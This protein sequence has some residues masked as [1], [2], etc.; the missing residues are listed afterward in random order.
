VR[1][2]MLSML[3]CHFDHSSGLV[4]FE[5]LVPVAQLVRVDVV[6]NRLPA[7][8]DFCDPSELLKG[9][10]RDV[11]CNQHRLASPIQP[12]PKD[13]PR[14][15]FVVSPREEERLHYFIVE[16]GLAKSV[17]DSKLDLVAPAGQCW[18]AVSGKTNA[19]SSG[20]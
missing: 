6:Q 4:D 1:S 15:G 16:R 17:L 5:K 19:T 3:E 2:D 8:G 12:T 13:L 20:S 18:R 14:H 10:R 11:L 9:P 7:P